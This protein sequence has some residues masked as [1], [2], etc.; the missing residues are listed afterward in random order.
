MKKKVKLGSVSLQGQTWELDSSAAHLRGRMCPSE[1]L[2]FLPVIM[3]LRHLVHP[4]TEC[5]ARACSGSV[6]QHFFGDLG[7]WQ[8]VHSGLSGPASLLCYS[9]LQASSSR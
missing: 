6:S 9:S 4:S 1:Q 2:P 7:K 5:E 8:S 3:L